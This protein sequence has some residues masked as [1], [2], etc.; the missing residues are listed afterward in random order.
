MSFS[1]TKNI[2]GVT[3]STRKEILG[4]S[5]YSLP[6]VPG[7]AGFS[8]EEIRSAFWKPIADN[9]SEDAKSALYE[10]DRVAK[11]A[12]ASIDEIRNAVSSSEETAAKETSSVYSALDSSKLS[13]IGVNQTMPGYLSI[14]KS[15]G[16]SVAKNLRVADVYPCVTLSGT[17]VTLTL[18]ANKEYYA[19]KVTSLTLSF[20]SS[21]SV[22]D[23]CYLCFTAGTG[24]SVT[25]QTTNASDISPTFTDG[26][27]YEIMGKWNGSIWMLAVHEAAV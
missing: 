14:Y 11:E 17:E 19:G 20:P 27:V 13:D 5:A 24:C 18:V 15:S 6:D 23:Y 1:Y 7:D 2:S 10:I 4:K 3:E 12:Q 8:A 21:A 26:Y 16:G 9:S 25:V 22:G